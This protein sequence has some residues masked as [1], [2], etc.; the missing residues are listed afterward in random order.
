MGIVSWIILGLIAGFI[1][2]KTVDDRVRVSGSTSSLESS[3]LSS[4]VFSLICS[5]H[6]ESQA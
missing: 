2:S 3:V 4:A 1:G 5:A 6:P